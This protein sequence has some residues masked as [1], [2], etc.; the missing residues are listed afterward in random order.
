MRVLV[1]AISVRPN[2]RACR[3][4][5]TGRTL[6]DVA[7]LKQH[8]VL[9]AVLP[10]TLPVCPGV[11]VCSVRHRRA[12]RPTGGTA[13]RPLAAARTRA[14]LARQWWGLSRIPW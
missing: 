14:R 13:R 2:A 9:T 11:V 3:H 6:C 8:K 1:G 7:R 4:I 10:A 5:H 12:G